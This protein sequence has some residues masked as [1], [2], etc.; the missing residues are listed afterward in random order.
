VIYNDSRAF[1]EEMAP[2]RNFTDLEGAPGQ[3]LQ[4]L[5]GDGQVLVNF[6]NAGNA[7][8]VPKYGE[9]LP[10]DWSLD[11]FNSWGILSDLIEPA[12]SS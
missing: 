9:W 4:H 6:L 5:N 8:I 7:P 3:E 2:L 12:S 11:D 1:V 10:A